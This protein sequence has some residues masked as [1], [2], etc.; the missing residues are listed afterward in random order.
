M[1]CTLAA[2]NEGANGL[3]TSST[4]A[5]GKGVTAVASFDN[6]VTPRLASRGH[7]TVGS[8]S[9]ND[10]SLSTPST[11]LEKQHMSFAWIPGWP[12]PFENIS[13]PLTALSN[14]NTTADACSPLPDNTLDLSNSVVLV[15]LGGC[16]VGKKARN[17]MARNGDYILF[18]SETY[19]RLLHL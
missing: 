10:M 19:V 11:P 2:G 17:V 3:F 14:Y 6:I 8:Q 1:P 18:Y 15:S 4:A 9:R 7:Y 5:D 16:D 13:L 12:Y